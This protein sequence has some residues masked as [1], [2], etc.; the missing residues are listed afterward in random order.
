MSNA[1]NCSQRSETCTEPHRLGDIHERLLAIDAYSAPSRAARILTGLGF[2]EEMQGQ[3]LDN[4]SGGWKM[5]VALAALLF[6]QPDVLLLDEPS[7]HLDL[8]AT[9]WLENFLKS[10]PATLIVISH[11][12]DLLNNVVDHILHLQGGSSRSTRAAT[13]ASNASAPNAR[14]SWLR[15]RPRRTLSAPGCRITSPATAPA[16]RPP[17]RRSRARRCWPRCSQS[18]H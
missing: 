9:L 3:P 14:P 5:R 11:E 17:N 1:R 15:R 16:P 12:R 13:T 10:Y 4:F 2:D 18:P 7:N 6:S 8:E